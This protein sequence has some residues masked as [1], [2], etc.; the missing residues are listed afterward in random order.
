MRRMIDLDQVFDVNMI[1]QPIRKQMDTFEITDNIKNHLKGSSIET[2]T[3]QM[4]EIHA[5]TND[6][7][8]NTSIL[9]TYSVTNDIEVP[10]AVYVD[11]EINNINSKTLKEDDF[12]I[13]KIMAPYMDIDIYKMGEKRIKN[14]KGRDFRSRYTNT[15]AKMN[16]VKTEGFT[17]NISQLN[18]FETDYEPDGITG[19]NRSELLEDFREII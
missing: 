18:T 1:N 19:I 10:F 13:S 14:R 3:E 5:Y 4:F 15:S 6:L 12:L 17:W 8:S 2:L 11:P 7:N 9:T 16:N